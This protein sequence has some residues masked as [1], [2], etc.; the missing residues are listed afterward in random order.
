[1]PAELES[2]VHFPLN[3]EIFHPA[4]SSVL[5]DSVVSA[6][7]SHLGVWGLKWFEMGWRSDDV[8]WCPMSRAMAWP[9]HWGCA[10]ARSFFS[11][12]AWLHRHLH[13]TW[14]ALGSCHM[15]LSLNSVSHWRSKSSGW[16]RPDRC[17]KCE[18][19]T[20]NAVAAV[21]KAEFHQI[22]QALNHNGKT[23]SSVSIRLQ[24]AALALVFNVG[25]LSTCQQN[26]GG[27]QRCWHKQI[28]QTDSTKATCSCVSGTIPSEWSCHEGP[29][30]IDPPVKPE[31]FHASF[32]PKIVIGSFIQRYSKLSGLQRSF[33]ATDL[34]K[35]RQAN[36]IQ[37][38]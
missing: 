11:L 7:F 16:E 15:N 36:K 27:F 33:Q 2:S 38:I 17:D 18:T 10:F 20:T 29:F 21:K 24:L 8:R 3:R 13:I 25:K 34:V 35:E 1:M 26:G 22:A 6:G 14:V 12:C 37:Q 23:V 31:R 19:V 30:G 28:K 32:M 9:G 4:W 5:S